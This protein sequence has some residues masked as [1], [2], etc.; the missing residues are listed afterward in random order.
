MKKLLLLL[1]IVGYNGYAQNEENIIESKLICKTVDEFTDAKSLSGTETVVLYEDGGD[2]SSE[3]I[4]LM[5]FLSEDK[6]GKIEPSTL[7]LKV[8]GIKGCVDIGSTLDLIFE[9]GEK[10]QLSNWKK[11]DCEGKNYF[12]LKGNEDLFKT[13]KIKAIKYTNKRNYDSMIVK[14]NMDQVGSSYLMNMLL[15][16]DKIN[17][18]EIS[19]GV[20]K[21]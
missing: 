12:S 1:L 3:G 19:L 10:T 20:C 6:R 2:M 13:S 7:Y 5:L 9:N 4:I 18:G 11:F 8:L 15:E 14:T 16:I 17:S 21:E